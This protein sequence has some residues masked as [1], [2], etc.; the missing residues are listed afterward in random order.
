MRRRRGPVFRP[1]ASINVK[2]VNAKRPF[3]CRI[4][5]N[6]CLTIAGTGSRFTKRGKN[7]A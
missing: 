5:L 3:L 2:T 7:P 6:D 4:L 1:T